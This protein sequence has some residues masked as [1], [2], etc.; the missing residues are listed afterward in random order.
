MPQ[1][2]YLGLPWY[3]S[4][5]RGGD[6]LSSAAIEHL[7]QQTVASLLSFHFGGE[8]PLPDA[9]AAEAVGAVFLA[10]FFFLGGGVGW[11]SS[12]T[13]FFGGACWAAAMAAARSRSAA[14]RCSSAVAVICCKYSP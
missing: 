6:P 14:A 13:I 11:L 10:G 8:V 1:R 3:G 4:A 12:T 2:R 9:V 7:I 5:I